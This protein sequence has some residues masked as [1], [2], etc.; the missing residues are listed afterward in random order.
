MQLRALRLESVSAGVIKGA[1]RVADIAAAGAR[2]GRCRT[3]SAPFSPLLNS[4]GRVAAA[5]H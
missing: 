5:I 1:C 3:R 2:A 4:P